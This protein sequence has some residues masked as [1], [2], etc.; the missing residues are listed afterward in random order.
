MGGYIENDLSG[1]IIVRNGSSAVR[2]CGVN[3][4]INGV[5]ER[6]KKHLGAYRYSGSD[7]V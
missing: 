5:F 4:S 3:V 6:A 1:S 7:Y 2:S